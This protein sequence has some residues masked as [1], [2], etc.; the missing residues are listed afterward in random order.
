MSSSRSTLLALL[1]TFFACPAVQPLPVD[2]PEVEADGGALDAGAADAGLVSPAPNDGGI[3]FLDWLVERGAPLSPVVDAELPGRPFALSA[4]TYALE[5]DCDAG[6]CT[7]RWYSNGA[8]LPRRHTGLTPT[9]TNPFSNDGTKFA[10]IEVTDRF[11]CSANGTSLP[12][13]EGTFGLYDGMTGARLFA[14]GPVVADPGLITNTFTQHGTIA[15]LDRY[16]RATCELMESTPLLTTAPFTRPAVLDAI[17]SDRGFP[18]YVE[19]DTADGQL[20]VSTRSGLNTPLGLARPGDPSSFRQLDGDHQLSRQSGG[21]LHVLGGWP[22]SRVASVHLAPGLRFDASLPSTEADFTSLVVS[23]RWVMGCAQTS[24]PQEKRCDAIDG[25]G[26]RAR[27]STLTGPALPAVAGALEAAVYRTTDG[28]VEQLDL[29]TGARSTLDVPAT[30]VRAVGNGAGFLLNDATHAWGLSRGAPFR[31]GERVLALYRGAAA[32]EQPQSDVVFIVSS[33]ETGSRVFLDVW[34]VKEGKVARVSNQLH[35][36][37]PFNAPF[38]AD[39]QCAVPGFLRSLGPSAASASQPG[40]FVHFTTFVP[41]AQPKLQ[42]FVM[43]SDLS[44][45]PRLLAELAPDQCSPP[46]VSPGGE[47]VWLPVVM[48]GGVRVVLAPL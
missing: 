8:T 29:V 18:P 40:R 31:L 27:R 41:A 4:T 22:Y 25:L 43:P 26:A 24:Q 1:T 11:M 38:T 32:V 6:A 13:V 48:N 15:R 2:Q 9:A 47:R 23:H 42:V 39:T 44:S 28:G 3:L 19:D 14:Q 30:T 35:F 16:D 5:D 7:Y 34:N 45:P 37:P 46:L 36:N 21:F 17:P 20:I 10:A 12:L 33:N